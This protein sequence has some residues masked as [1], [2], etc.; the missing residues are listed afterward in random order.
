M[1][2]RR[3]GFHLLTPAYRGRLE[4]N[5]I[6]ETSYNA[7]VS[8]KKARGKAPLPQNTRKGRAEARATKTRAAKASS[9]NEALAA[10]VQRVKKQLFSSSYKFRNDRSEKNTKTN[11]KTKKAPNPEYMQRFLNDPQGVFDS[12]T[13]DDNMDHEWW[14]LA[15]R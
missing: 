4:R 14:F 6:T 8:L 7:G 10:Q 3:K 9:A 2:G 5:G 1:A 13:W 12:L 15:Y 11:P